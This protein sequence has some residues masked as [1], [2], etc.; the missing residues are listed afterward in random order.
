[1]PSLVGSEM[2][3]RDSIWSVGKWDTALSEGASDYMAATITDDPAMGI[4]F[5]GNNDPLRHLDDRNRRWPEDI[6]EE[7]KTG[8]IFGG[9]MW[10]LR[11]N[12]IASHGRQDGIAKADKLMYLALKTASD[13]PTSYAELI[14]ADDDDGNLS[15]GTPNLCDINEA[16]G[17]HGLGDPLGFY[18]ITRP[19]LTDSVVTLS[20]STNACPGNEIE[21]I[22]L[23]W[24]HRDQ[25]SVSGRLTMA[26]N[27]GGYRTQL[28]RA[29]PGTVVNY[30]VEIFFADG[31]TATFPENP[32]SP[33]YEYFNGRVCLLYT[34]PSP[35]D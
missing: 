24:Q 3:I 22:T 18:G 10:D 5:F 32:A 6:G 31:N 15:N 7:H 27:S 12:L 25:P 26:P 1:M 23:K 17:K 4:G 13:I 9:A 35:R 11:Q 33:W 8:I 28:P 34:S 21:S 16:F 30:K 14:A 2:C 20:Q 29:A 19:L